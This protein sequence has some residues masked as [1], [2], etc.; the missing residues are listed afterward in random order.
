M[1]AAPL[2]DRIDDPRVTDRW[3]RRGPAT[4]VTLLGVV[5][6]HPASVARARIVAEAMGPDVLAL[7]LP[8]AAVPLYRH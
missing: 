5:H 7:E 1:P 4:N 3:C 2:V 8:A 6:D